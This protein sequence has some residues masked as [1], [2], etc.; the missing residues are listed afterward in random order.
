[1]DPVR[2]FDSQ[3]QL[4]KKVLDLR[5]DKAQTI[6]SNIANAETP[7]YSR[8][9]FDFEDDLKHAINRGKNLDLATSNTKHIALSPSNFESVVGKVTHVRDQTDIG[10][11]NGVSVDQEMI[12]L[13][14]NEILYETS[15][16]LLKKK[17]NLLKYVISGG[18]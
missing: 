9:V 1:M 15:A 3:M 6:S 7:G 2:P 13:S 17:L 5:A 10:D 8:A 11:Q 14:E 16:Q 4:L 18:Q 12:S